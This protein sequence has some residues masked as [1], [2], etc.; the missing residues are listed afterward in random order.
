MLTRGVKASSEMRDKV[1]RSLLSSSHS[2]VPSIYLS[3]SNL[4]N[5]LIASIIRLK[6]MKVPVL[7]IPA[8]QWVRTG[9]SG[10]LFLDLKVY[11]SKM[12]VFA[13]DK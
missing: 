2:S 4:C 7:P 5:S 9:E 11:S 6:A 8:L 1:G 10:W 12:G 3:S 13:R